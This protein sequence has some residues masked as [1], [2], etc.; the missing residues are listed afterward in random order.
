MKYFLSLGSNS[1]NRE[2]NLEAA[3]IRMKWQG[4]RI[5]L[6]SFFYETEPVAMPNEAWF[7]NQ[8][9]EVD[10][11]MAPADLLVWIKK[12]EA[13]MGRDLTEKYKS[14]VIDIDI[15]LAEDSVIQ[16]D[17][18]QIPHPKLTERNFVLVPF[19]EIAPEITHPVLHKK[20]YDLLMD[21]K[22]PH[23]VRIINESR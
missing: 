7:L 3:L 15:L 6:N 21:S 4:M 13:T 19:A 2:K 1:G 17:E 12:T 20:I 5:L 11:E 8:V 23:K 10:T 16:T 9:V 18:L 14:R 22:D